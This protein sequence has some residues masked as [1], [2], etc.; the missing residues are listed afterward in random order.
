MQSGC[1]FVIEMSL[2]TRWVQRLIRNR[3]PQTLRGSTLLRWSHGNLLDPLWIQGN[4]VGFVPCHHVD[5][6]IPDFDGAD[7]SREG[8]G[9]VAIS[10]YPSVCGC[11]NLEPTS[12]VSAQDA[13]HPTEV[14]SGNGLHQAW[15]IGAA[16]RLHTEHNVRCSFPDVRG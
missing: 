9:I 1:F 2:Q 7:K 11:L 5:D 6:S 4:C 3:C 15:Q 13:V 8:V 10:H 16:H 12:F 14:G